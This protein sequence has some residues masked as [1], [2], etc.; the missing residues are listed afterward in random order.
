M[1]FGS[2]TGMITSLR[3]NCR[4]K[5]HAAFVK[6]KIYK[7]KKGSLKD[8]DFPNATPELL[9]EIR[10]KLKAYNRKM[11]IQ[12]LIITILVLSVIVYFILKL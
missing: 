11:F 1:G 3:N 9:E 12:N 2:A 10:Q 5:V 7:T 8:Y 6:E 4:R